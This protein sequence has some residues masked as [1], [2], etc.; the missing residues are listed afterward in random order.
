MKTPVLIAAAALSAAPTA[1]A[2]VGPTPRLEE[3][4]GV[5]LPRHAAPAV[6]RDCTIN[7]AFGS[8]AVGIDGQTLAR[9]ERTLRLDRRV[10]R[11]TRHPWGR[12]GEVTLCVY[13]R[14]H[15]GAGPLARQLRAMIPARPRGPISVTLR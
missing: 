15:A 2:R 13:T 14:G 1:G 8:Y 3:P 11:F 6:P 9:M 12:E 7:V 10:R 5:A 4:V